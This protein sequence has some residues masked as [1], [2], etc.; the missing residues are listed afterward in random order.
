MERETNLTGTFYEN[1]FAVLRICWQITTENENINVLWPSR[2][3]IDGA[4][5]CELQ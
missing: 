2:M 4:H 3:L 1:F 5:L